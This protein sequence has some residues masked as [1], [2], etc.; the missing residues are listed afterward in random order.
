MPLRDT[1]LT[2]TYPIYDAVTGAYA[3]DA[4]SNHTY[5]LLADGVEGSVADVGDATTVTGFNKVIIAADENT[6]TMMTLK[7][8]TSSSGIRIPAVTW[9]NSAPGITMLQSDGG[10]TNL[11]IEFVQ[12]AAYDGLQLDKK[13]FLVNSLSSITSHTATLTLVNEHGRTVSTTTATPTHVTGTTYSVAFSVTAADT[14]KL[15]LARD[16]GTYAVKIVS[17]VSI[18]TPYAGKVQCLYNIDGRAA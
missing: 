14:A 7:I 15:N 6:G 11:T 4:A 16:A 18:A 5:E 9:D 13:T 3:T 17:G 12:G 10:Y 2:L 1:Q 8:T